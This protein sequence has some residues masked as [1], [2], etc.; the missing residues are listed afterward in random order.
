LQI[1]ID[2]SNFHG[3]LRGQAAVIRRSRFLERSTPHV[4]EP[5]SLL[6]L[7]NFKSLYQDL[8]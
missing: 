7:L 2:R 1:W 5:R 4:L 3:L 8:S 6:Q